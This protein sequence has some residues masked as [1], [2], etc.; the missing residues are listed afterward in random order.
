MSGRSVE[1]GIYPWFM[2]R[3]LPCSALWLHSR[4]SLK[5]DVENTSDE[6]KDRES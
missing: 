1:F 6:A 3:G 2:A 5:K 4:D